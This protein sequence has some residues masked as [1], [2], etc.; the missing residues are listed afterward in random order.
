MKVAM[1][2]A[3]RVVVVVLAL[4]GL[5]ALV[6]AYTPLANLLF[7]SLDRIPSNAEPAD[8]IVVLSGGRYGDGTLNGAA[9]E[10]TVTAVILYR[11]GLAPRLLFS[12]GPC[13]GRSTSSLM[14]ALARELG[15]PGEAIRLEE[16][17]HRTHD[18]AVRVAGVARAEGWR[19]VIL[20]TSAVHML[21]ARLAFVAAGVPVVPVKATERADRLV[22]TADERIAL[23]KASLHEY[24][25]LGLYKVRGWI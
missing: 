20:V 5:G 15:V 25:G 7:A 11:R 9:I 1:A 3:G 23:L 14:G 17:S 4:V 2:R 24:L 10:R 18:A 8:A 21:R 12:G 22:T 13:C 19:S 16:Q 6:V